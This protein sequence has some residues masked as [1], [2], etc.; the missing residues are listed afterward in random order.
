MR[1]APAPLR[2][3]HAQILHAA[4]R[5]GCAQCMRRLWQKHPMGSST[6]G[7]PL[8][9][10]CLWALARAA[11]WHRPGGAG[12]GSPTHAPASGDLAAC[13]PRLCSSR[14][15]LPSCPD[16]AALACYQLQPGGSTLSWV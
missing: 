2:S 13:G 10:R 7:L 1:H 15:A 3:S 11:E 4:S 8:T 14:R 9:C 12:P 5:P 6:A 16:C